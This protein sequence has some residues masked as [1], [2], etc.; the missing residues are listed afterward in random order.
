MHAGKEV[1]YFLIISFKSCSAYIYNAGQGLK[2]NS[3][4]VLPSVPLQW[5]L[6]IIFELLTKKNCVLQIM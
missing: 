1:T 3:E 5:H 6:D 4:N 2:E